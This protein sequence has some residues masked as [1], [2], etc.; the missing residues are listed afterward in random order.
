MKSR[1]EVEYVIVHLVWKLLKA[2]DGG[3]DQST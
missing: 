3:M 1:F 2:M